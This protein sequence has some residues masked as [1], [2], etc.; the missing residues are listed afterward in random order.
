LKE[1]GQNRTVALI[2]FGDVTLAD[3]MDP[4]LSVDAQHPEHIGRLAA[5]RILARIS[6]DR[7]DPRTYIV[8]SRMVLRGSGEVPPPPS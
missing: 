3:M 8:P 2:G 1:Q 4:G 7:Q 6:G 5:E